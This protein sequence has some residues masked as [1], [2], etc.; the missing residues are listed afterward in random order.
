MIG[1]RKK[2]VG[3][4][5]QDIIRLTLTI[6]QRMLDPITLESYETILKKIA[7]FFNTNLNVRL[8]KSTGRSYYR[9]VGSSRLSI[10]VI[11]DYLDL[12]SLQSSKRLNY[13]D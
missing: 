5:N 8:Q 6:E 3:G 1:Y 7:I 11:V 10:S 13:E 2:I 9:I 12:Y 4:V